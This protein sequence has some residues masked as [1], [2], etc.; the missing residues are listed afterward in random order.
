[1][2]Q[3]Q[4]SFPDGQTIKVDKGAPFKEI[5]A[6]LNGRIEREAIAVKFNGDYFDLSHPVDQDGDLVFLTASDPEGL[7]IYWHSSAHI[8]AHAIKT[9]FPEAKFAFGP[10]VEHGFYYD[11]DLS[12]PLTPDDLEL[13]EKKM[14]EIVA[15]DRPFVRE[16]LSKQEAI[17]LFRR[18]NETYKVEQIE[19]LGEPPS[20]Y[21]EGNF[22]DL[23]RGPHLPST[24]RLKH[25]KLTSVAGAYWLADE[26]NPMLQRVYGISFPKKSQLDDYLR[27][28]EEA[29]KRDHRRLG[30]ELD[31]FSINDEI[32]PGL[33][34]WH[35]KG[36][37]IRHKIEQFWRE[38]HLENGYDFV[39]SPHIA[40][41]GLWNTSGHLDFFS[42][43]MYSP[44][45]VDE[46][47]YIV[48]PM[49]CPFHLQIFKSM[50]RSYRDL[51]IRWAELGTVYRYERSGVLHGL[52]RVR[53]FTQDDAHIFCTPDQLEDEI[54]RLISF[55]LNMLDA[56]GFEGY[57]I[58]LSTRPEEYVGSVENWDRATEALKK[59][60]EKADI[61][62]QIDPGE[63][64][65]YGPKI[66]IKIR[67]VLG[68]SWQC[69]TL[70]VDFNEP[71]RFNLSYIGTDGAKHRPIMIHRALLGSLERFFGVLIEHY[72]G[73][74]PLWLAPVQVRVLPI[75]D[76]QHRYAADVHQALQQ[77]GIR[78]HIDDRS[79]KVGYKIRESETEKIP[80]MLVLGAR[81]AEAGVVS[82]RKRREGDLGQKSLDEF[83]VAVKE[84][85][86]SREL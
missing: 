17:D 61:D 38:R 58:F 52:M 55:C 14:K 48:K 24:G 32:G 18:L 68:R 5:L 26:R 8:M 82:V 66:D 1:V 35:P 74:F 69:S 34:L 13:I 84:E 50:T 20:I 30:R 21:K 12:R 60:L 27:T 54:D 2:S 36:S 22:V 75:T 16:N 76:A 56:F 79:E 83:I 65:F 49:N 10:P 15:Q 59:G 51:P 46:M 42:E 6:H 44:M 80:Y 25:F 53:G 33:V 86:A 7:D 47:E 37:F 63:G 40:R 11:V 39:N 19:R 62:Y 9:L 72:A 71:E 41:I 70:Q 31:L 67:D 57:D 45:N 3:V 28:L 81:E 29:K 43:N 23:C 64:V 77:A 78:S 73:A 85:T 4:I